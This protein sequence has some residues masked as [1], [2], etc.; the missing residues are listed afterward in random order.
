VRVFRPP[1]VKGWKETRIKG[2]LLITREAGTGGRIPGSED[3]G[4]EEESDALD[5][6]EAIRKKG[7]SVE[8]ITRENVLDGH[9]VDYVKNRVAF[10]LEW[11]SKDQTFDRR[12]DGEARGKKL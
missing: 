7:W 8:H 3:D 1:S 5:G 2:D 6:I 9:K 4:E 10:D 11:N 12:H